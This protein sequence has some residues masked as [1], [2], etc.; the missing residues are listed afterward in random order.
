[1]R[2]AANVPV[3]LEALGFRVIC[4]YLRFELL[5]LGFFKIVGWQREAKPITAGELPSFL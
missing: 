2:A 3:S 5:F 1:M 4:F